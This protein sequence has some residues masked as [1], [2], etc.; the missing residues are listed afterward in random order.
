MNMGVI[1]LDRRYRD[2]P[3]RFQIGAIFTFLIVFSL[4]LLSMVSFQQYT[5]KIKADSL[6]Q[7]LELKE[8]KRYQIMQYLHERLHDIEL[9]SQNPSVAQALDVMDYVHAISG[10]ASAGY[11]ENMRRFEPFF[12]SY[13]DKA[14]YEDLLLISSAANVVFSMAAE[15][16]LGTNLITGKFRDTGLAHAYRRAMIGLH[17]EYS[18]IEY[19]PPSKGPASFIVSPIIIDGGIRGAIALQLAQ[20]A[21]NEVIMDRSGL[22]DTGETVVAHRVKGAAMVVAPLRHLPQAALNMSIPLDSAA[23]RPIQLAVQGNSGHGTDV[24]YRGMPVLAAWGYLPELQMGMV[25]KID[26]A[27]LYAPITYMKQTAL[28]ISSLIILFAVSCVFLLSGTISG[29]IK[30]LATIIERY[31]AGDHEVRSELNRKDEIGVWSAGFNAMAESIGRSHEE[32][33]QQNRLLEDA[34]QHLER[35]VEKRTATLAAA[36]EELK[37]LAYIVS[38][39]LR[40]PLVN[41]KG[42]ASELGYSIAEINDLLEGANQ[43]GKQEQKILSELTEK[44]I[45]ESMDFIR[46]SA[47]KMDGLLNAILKLSRFGSRK[48]QLEEIDMVALSNS[49]LETLSYQLENHN[50]EVLIRALPNIVND[51]FVMDR[52]IG[53]LLDNAVKYLADDRNGHIEISAKK[54]QRGVEFSVSDNGRGIAKENRDKVFTIFRRGAHEDIAGEGMGLAYVQTMVRSQ[55]GHISFE[56]TPGEGSCFSFYLPDGKLDVPAEEVV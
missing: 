24:D 35:R 13:R 6:T 3:I 36:N 55:G 8:S 10:A 43:L 18:R 17:A 42:F 26:Q 56:S 38:H 53:N 45:P 19:Y 34:K 41:I 2:L 12:R 47:E 25:V 16:D 39:D 54:R 28:L 40:A 51:R 30:Q 22:R 52:I 7:L 15:A 4:G 27:E 20:H 33:R 1:R 9:L 5:A 21:L 44:D 14:D 31:G 50:T 29:P 48:L 23:G 46:I 11:I 49:I 37:S 32:I